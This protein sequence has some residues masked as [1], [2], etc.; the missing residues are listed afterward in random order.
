[1]TL[2]LK[3]AGDAG[4]NDHGCNHRASP[5]PGTVLA[6]SQ[7]HSSPLIGAAEWHPDEADVPTVDASRRPARRA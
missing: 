6:A 5:L 4:G 2:R 1:M 3:A 7:P